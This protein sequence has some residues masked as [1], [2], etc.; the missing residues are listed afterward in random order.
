MRATR[1]LRTKKKTST[2]YKCKITDSKQ[3]TRIGCYPGFISRLTWRYTSVSVHEGLLGSKLP[4]EK[5]MPH[6]QNSICYQK[7]LVRDLR[8]QQHDLPDNCIHI[9]VYVVEGSI[10]IWAFPSLLL[11]QAS[12]HCHHSAHLPF[13]SLL[14]ESGCPRKEGQCNTLTPKIPAKW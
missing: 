9:S 4:I 12:V 3:R 2:T 1:H 14:I 11:T 13:P 8:C 7:I 6:T 10:T 5:V